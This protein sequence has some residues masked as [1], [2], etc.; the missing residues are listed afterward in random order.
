[1]TRWLK[2]CVVAA[3]LS[4]SAVASVVA[5]PLDTA[6]VPADSKW[7]IHIDMDAAKKSKSWKELYDRL[8]LQG[9]FVEKVTELEQLFNASFPDDIHGITLYGP[10]FGEKDGVVLIHADVG[11]K[12]VEQMLTLAPGYSS[13]RHGD[14]QVL[15]WD[16][17]GKINFGG[18]FSDSV[19]LIGQDKDRVGAVF[20]VL[21]NKAASL[22]GDANLVKGAKGGVMFYVAGDELAKLRQM[23]AVRS[24]LLAQM[25]SA[26]IGLVE[27]KDDLVLKLNVQAN[28][29]ATAQ[30]MQQAAEGLRALLNLGAAEPDAKPG[31][32]KLAELVAGAQLKVDGNTVSTDL[33]IPTRQIPAMLDQAF[34]NQPPAEKKQ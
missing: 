20:D 29:A 4:L 28:D 22:K 18:F 12:Q 17:K 26:W 16:D 10:T 24:P 25:K 31:V 13:T 14:Y 9:E 33:R 30:K 34:A 15:S 8:L 1:M 27:D 5:D 19:F 32:K 2:S 23:Q 7:V 21:A 11:R 3:G 6:R